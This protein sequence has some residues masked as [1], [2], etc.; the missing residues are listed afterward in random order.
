[1]GYFCDFQKTAQSKQS[2]NGRKFAPSGHPVHHLV[3]RD[4]RHLLA[5]AMASDDMLPSLKTLY[6]AF[7]LLR[8]RCMYVAVNSEVVRL[9]PE[10][11]PLE[12]DLWVRVCFV[13][14]M[15]YIDHLQ[16]VP[17]VNEVTLAGPAELGSFVAEF[18]VVELTRFT[19]SRVS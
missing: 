1:V 9:A 5:H 15:A 17:A 18:A 6:V 7:Y 16:G 11:K 8:W 13:L 14:L 4:D 10:K 2:P 12:T 3:N 19:G